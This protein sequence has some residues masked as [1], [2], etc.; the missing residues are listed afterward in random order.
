MLVLEILKAVSNIYREWLCMWVAEGKRNEFSGERIKNSHSEKQCV[1]SREIVQK[2][3]IR[4]I[5]ISLQIFVLKIMNNSLF[6]FYIYKTLF[7]SWL[8]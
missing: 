3:T 1:C 4:S 2:E 6:T 7:K 8:L 5:F